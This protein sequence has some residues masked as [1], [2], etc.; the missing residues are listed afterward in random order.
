MLDNKFTELIAKKLSGEIGKDE[1]NAL[2]DWLASSDE[3]R[4]AFNLYHA[5]WSD[6]KIN[7]ASQNAN[8][9]FVGISAAIQK[10]EKP[11]KFHAPGKSRSIAYL[12]RGIAAAVLIL[13]VALFVFDILNAKEEA[14]IVQSTQMIEKSLSTGQK[15]KIFLPD[16]ST[17]WLNAESSISYPERFND[18]SRIVTLKGEAFFDVTKNPNKP[19]IVKTENMD[20][21]VLGTA[22]NVRNYHNEGKIDVALESGK[23]LVETSGPIRD[24]YVLSPGE[25]I[26]MNEKSG[27]AAKYSVDPKRAFQWKDG[28]LYFHKA[29]F[30]EVINKLGRW[31]GVEFIVENYNREKWE[32]SA[33]FRNDYLSNVLQSMSFTKGFEYVIDQNKVTIKFN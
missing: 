24:K 12:W 19:F 32:Y 7:R 22:F 5:I 2:N 16:G 17:V 33:E 14:R 28:V 25:G 9:V 11:D 31:Y 8:N 27:N 21:S 6:M 29:N 18:S 3:N 20:I 1:E 30:D 26:S 13:V 10:E 15:L 23:L 4:E